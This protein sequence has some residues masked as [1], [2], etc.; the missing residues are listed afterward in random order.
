MIIQ[1]ALVTINWIIQIIVL[2]IKVKMIMKIWMI[3]INLV[4]KDKA[5]IIIKEII[6]DMIIDFKI[7]IIII[8]IKILIKYDIYG[9]KYLEIIKFQ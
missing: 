1:I 6:I 2:T 3:M 8:I 5:N 9:I 7:K 4:T